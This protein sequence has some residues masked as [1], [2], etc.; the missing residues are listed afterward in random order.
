M[1]ASPFEFAFL[2]LKN[3]MPKNSI[4][5][6]MHD[7]PEA[8]AA[9]FGSDDPFEFYADEADWA[10]TEG[11]GLS[12]MEGNLHPHNLPCSTCDELGEV[13]GHTI[14]YCEGA[15]WALDGGLS[16]YPTMCDTRL[17]E[18]IEWANEDTKGGTDP[19][20]AEWIQ[21][22]QPVDWSIG[23]AYYPIGYRSAQEYEEGQKKSLVKANPY[24][25]AYMEHLDHTW[26]RGFG[27]GPAVHQQPMG[28]IHPAILGLMHRNDPTRGLMMDHRI[29]VPEERGK[30]LIDDIPT[31]H[32]VAE[33][34]YNYDDWKRSYKGS[35]GD[36][37]RLYPE[38]PED[39]DDEE[40]NWDH[41]RE[42]YRNALE[43]EGVQPHPVPRTMRILPERDEGWGHVDDPEWYRRD[44]EPA[45]YN[46][47]G[48]FYMEERPAI[49]SI[50]PRNITPD[51]TPEFSEDD[52]EDPDFWEHAGT[53]WREP[54][55]GSR[56]WI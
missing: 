56:L 42:A 7:D 10:R 34:I 36:D 18:A 24:E 11:G 12:Q 1:M 49:T 44:F 46:E 27:Q 41:E 23:A 5:W 40:K 37:Y 14:T 54:Q 9:H 16:G 32:L 33:P 25:Q 8:L 45:G 48:D 2:F 53:D 35:L 4:N 17:Q 15:K 22:I 55:R 3:E 13:D 39:W 21:R 43:D 51:F 26:P 28:T 20:M 31:R 30:G 29:R 52:T 38:D 19:E 6:G 50:H 47:E